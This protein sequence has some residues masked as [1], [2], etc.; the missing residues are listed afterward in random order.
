[1]GARKEEQKVTVV[2]PVEYQHTDETCPNVE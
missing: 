2:A 1:V